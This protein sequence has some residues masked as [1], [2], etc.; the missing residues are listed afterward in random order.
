MDGFL[1]VRLPGK[2]GCLSPETLMKDTENCMSTPQT[3][4]WPGQRMWGPDRKET[5][6]GAGTDGKL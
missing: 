2:T 4:L 5:D 6:K 1:A 3:M